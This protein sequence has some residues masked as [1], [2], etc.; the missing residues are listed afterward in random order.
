MRRADEIIRSCYR[1]DD[2]VL[3]MLH[4]SLLVLAVHSDLDHK[5]APILSVTLLG[6]MQ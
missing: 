4:G 3:I 6:V 2:A 5:T 1:V